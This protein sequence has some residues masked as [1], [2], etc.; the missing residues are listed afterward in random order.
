MAALASPSEIICQRSELCGKP[1]VIQESKWDLHGPLVRG[2]KLLSSQAP[3]RV[4]EG[5]WEGMMWRRGNPFWE[6]TGRREGPRTHPG[7]A[8]KGHTHK[9][10]AGLGS[11]EGGCYGNREKV[12]QVSGDGSET[13]PGKN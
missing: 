10:G 7:S 4:T 8:G 2:S 1:G 5:G 12:R 6:D 3:S 13:K 9:E 11:P